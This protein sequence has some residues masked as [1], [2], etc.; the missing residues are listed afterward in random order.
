MLYARE[1][2]LGRFMRILKA[3]YRTG[4]DFLA[5]YQAS[6]SNGGLFFPTREH[7]TVGEGVMVEVRF[8]ELGDRMLLRCYVAWRRSAR[9]REGTPAGVG[10][11][12]D[13]AERGKR[14]F[15]LQ[16]ARGAARPFVRSH[17]RLPVSLPARWHVAHARDSHPAVIADV[18]AGGA[19]LATTAPCPAGTQIVVELV[20][21]GGAAPLDIEAR[22]VWSRSE[23]GREGLGIEFRCRDT[24]GL[25]RL[26][27]MVR[28]LERMDEDDAA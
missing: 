13:G 20:P 12:I 6:F 27:E 28:R 26:K 4:K 1:N 14:D 25:R 9:V 21:P 22:V 19:F 10:V 23:P 3:R 24:G 15:L 11:E 7:A 8:P 16:V 2:E 5:A 17:R 18:S